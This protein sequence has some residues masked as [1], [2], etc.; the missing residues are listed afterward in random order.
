MLDEK[1]QSDSEHVAY[2]FCTKKISFI[3]IDDD[4]L[5]EIHKFFFPVQQMLIK[6]CCAVNE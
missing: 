5:T 4:I 1:K 6:E 3:G 2:E